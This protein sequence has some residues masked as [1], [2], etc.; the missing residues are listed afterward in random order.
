M[1]HRAFTL[2]EVLIVVIILGI[3]AAAIIP[4]FSEAA[5]DGRAN[6]AAMV[7]RGIQ[8]QITVKR[9]QTGSWPA[10]IDATWFEGGTLP[11]NPLDPD[12]TSFCNIADDVA[13]LHPGTKTIHVAGA[14]WYN[15]ANGIIRARVTAGASTAETIALYN[16]VNATKVTSLSQTK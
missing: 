8:R 13:L 1:S 9:A 12:A 2:I 5:D 4:Q 7:V 16:T 6:T 3:L 11:T 14:F 15:K 10:N